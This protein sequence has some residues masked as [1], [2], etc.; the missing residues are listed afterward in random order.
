MLKLLAFLSLPHRFDCEVFA[1]LRH[2]RHSRWRDTSSCNL[3]LGVIWNVISIP[4]E[5]TWEGFL[6]E[7]RKRRNRVTCQPQLFSDR[8]AWKLGG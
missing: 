4:P 8:C 5:L 1:V 3:A 7:K 6:Q 2:I